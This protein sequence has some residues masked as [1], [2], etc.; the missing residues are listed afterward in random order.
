[1]YYFSTF[2][3]DCQFTRLASAIH[4]FSSTPNLNEL[5]LF[6]LIEACRILYQKLITSSTRSESINTQRGD[7]FAEAQTDV[8]Y[9]R[10]L[11]KLKLPSVTEVLSELITAS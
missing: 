9:L 7:T 10:D 3:N 6:F 8:H 1:M 11:K 4:Y 5:N 2:C